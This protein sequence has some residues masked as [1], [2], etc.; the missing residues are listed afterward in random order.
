MTC[1]HSK[2]IASLKEDIDEYHNKVKRAGEIRESFQQRWSPTL[3]TLIKPKMEETKKLL[4]E[5]GIQCEIRL[6][7][8][9][10]KMSILPQNAEG[11][12]DRWPSISFEPDNPKV[13]V[14]SQY[15]TEKN[16]EIHMITDFEEQR[17]ERLLLQFVR[18]NLA[19]W[20]PVW[21]R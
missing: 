20:S 17:I 19:L 18:H 8:D 16:E 6:P 21:I 7:L 10:I 11:D 4:E 1:M 9:S 2:G 12:K 5:N 13:K 3:N 15:P 14:T